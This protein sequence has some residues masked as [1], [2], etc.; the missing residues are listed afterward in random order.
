MAESHVL[1]I[2]LRKQM[3]MLLQCVNKI[4]DNGFARVRF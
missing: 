2:F 3:N 4:L 1:P